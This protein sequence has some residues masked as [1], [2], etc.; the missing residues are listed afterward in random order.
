MHASY[1]YTKTALDKDNSSFKYKPH[2]GEMGDFGS[3]ARDIKDKAR[4]LLS[5]QKV[6]KLPK[7][8]GRHVKRML[9][10]TRGSSHCPKEGQLQQQQKVMTAMD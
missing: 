4:I 7:L 3:G 1:T 2:L 8:P 6:R 5:H 10:T 9:K